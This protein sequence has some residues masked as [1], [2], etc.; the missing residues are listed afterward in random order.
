MSKYVPVTIKD[1]QQQ[2]HNGITLVSSSQC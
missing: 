2:L 1:C